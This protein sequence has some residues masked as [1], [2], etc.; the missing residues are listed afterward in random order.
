MKEIVV[1]SVGS[2]INDAVDNRLGRASYFIFI[3]PQT[4]EYEAIQNPFV[5]APSA[6]GMQAAN[7]I[8][9]KG[10]RIVLAP[11]VGPNVFNVLQSAGIKIYEV[12]PNMTVKQA[13]EEYK[14]GT[15]KPLSGG[16][17]FH[18]PHY[19]S[20]P[21]Q[22]PSWGQQQFG[23]PYGGPWYPPYPGYP[24]NFAPYYP[25]YPPFPPEIEIQMLKNLK[26]MLEE[27]L[28]FI[29]QRLKELEGNY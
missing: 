1:P 5:N 15:L 10:A 24:W 3:D 25:P 19:Q 21:S 2:S 18:A 6:A 13:V 7:L 12:S 8:V 17:T 20:A 4:L 29:E 22:S 11:H 14:K 9:Q 26:S 23:G 27:Q 28:K 16:P